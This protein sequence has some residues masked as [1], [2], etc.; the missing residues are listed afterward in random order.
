MRVGQQHASLLLQE[1]SRKSFLILQSF[2]A[3]DPGISRSL[4]SLRLLTVLHLKDHRQVTTDLLLTNPS[5]VQKLLVDDCACQPDCLQE[6]DVYQTAPARF[7]QTLRV[8]ELDSTSTNH[9]L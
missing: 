4:S 1:I 5:P 3:M 7:R 2:F 9:F 8:M 6:V